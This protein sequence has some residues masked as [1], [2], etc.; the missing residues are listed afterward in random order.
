MDVPHPLV[1]IGMY[2]LG[3]ALVLLVNLT[4]EREE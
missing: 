2:V 4:L 1:I 3:V